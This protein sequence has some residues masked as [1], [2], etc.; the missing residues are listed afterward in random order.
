[1]KTTFKTTLEKF[2][3]SLYPYHVKVPQDIYKSYAEA[4]I[5]RIIVNFNG[6]TPV[7]NAFLSKGGNIKYIKLNKIT[8]KEG[9]LN[10]GDEVNVEI[11][12]DQ[13]RYGVPIAPEMEELLIQDVE[14]EMLFH[15]LTAGKIRSLL[16]KINSYKSSDK[17][18]ETSIVILEHLKGNGGE[19]DW[20]MLNEAIK[21]G[22]KL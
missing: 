2:E 15:K 22:F 12:E 21:I 10:V 9:N 1:M 4:K 3:D 20:K 8:M 19:L 13:S 6:G 7:H 18:I 16:F 11:K 5:K 17:R 14:G